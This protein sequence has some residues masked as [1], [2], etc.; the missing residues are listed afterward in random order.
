MDTGILY[1]T[2][3]TIELQKLKVMGAMEERLPQHL[4]NILRLYIK[5]VAYMTSTRP[6]LADSEYTT[7]LVHEPQKTD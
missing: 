5:H 7:A 4:R 1:P 6:C 3:P 2:K